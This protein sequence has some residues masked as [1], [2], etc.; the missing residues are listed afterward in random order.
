M[1][2]ID[3]IKKILEDYTNKNSSELNNYDNQFSS[4]LDDYYENLQKQL[5]E[6]IS[7]NFPTSI[8]QIP[9]KS[10]EEVNLEQKK[11]KDRTSLRWL[12]QFSSKDHV[13]GFQNGG[14][15]Y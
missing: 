9:N 6:P 12:T 3:E 4:E 10:K 11:D 8:F 7:I 13:K 15:N 5:E 1:F 14:Q 2:N